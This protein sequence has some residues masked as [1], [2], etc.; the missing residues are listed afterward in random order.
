[1]ILA[2]CKLLPHNDAVSPIG[3]IPDAYLL[4]GEAGE[5]EG[6]QVQQVACLRGE[7][8]ARTLDEERVV[9]LNKEPKLFSMFPETRQGG[10]LVAVVQ[11]FHNPSAFSL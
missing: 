1:M 11:S 6:V 5:L 4:V 2:S 8:D 7:L 9:V 10:R 3:C